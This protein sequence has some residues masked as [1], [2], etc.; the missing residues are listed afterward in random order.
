[1]LTIDNDID[2]IGTSATNDAY[3]PLNQRNA[4]HS[5]IVPSVFSAAEFVGSGIVASG[6]VDA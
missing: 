1:M 4:S 3:D 6:A 2:P 5:P